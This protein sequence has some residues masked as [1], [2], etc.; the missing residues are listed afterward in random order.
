MNI[1]NN[2][3]SGL[4]VG[5]WIITK[6]FPKIKIYKCVAQVIEITPVIEVKFARRVRKNSTLLAKF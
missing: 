3:V 6:F 5:V 4:K 1:M 2:N